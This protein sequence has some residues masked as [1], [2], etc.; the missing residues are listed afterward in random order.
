MK[1]LIFTMAFISITVFAKG[2]THSSGLVNSLENH[3]QS[4]SVML[5]QLENE[6]VKG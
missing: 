1:Y 2:Y 5:D 3:N 4:I 6:T